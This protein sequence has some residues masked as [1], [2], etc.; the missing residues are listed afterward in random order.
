MKK[1]IQDGCIGIGNFT[2][3]NKREESS[4]LFSFFKNRIVSK[5][6]WKVEKLLKQ[7]GLE[8]YD[9]M[10]ILAATNGRSINDRYWLEETN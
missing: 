7:Y 2:L 10:K 1:A 5:D 8:E 9:E 3:L 6:S 4:E